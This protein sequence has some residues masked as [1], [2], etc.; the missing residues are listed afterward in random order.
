METGQLGVLLRPKSFGDMIGQEDVVKT[1]Q[2]QLGK[3]E[4][5]RA[6]M[7]I[8]PAGT[9]KTTLG[10]IIAREIQGWEFPA[11]SEPDVIEINAANKRKIED[12]RSLVDDTQ[13]FPFQGKYRVII[14]DEAQQITKEG[15]N[16]L[17]KPFEEKDSANVWIICTTDPQKIIEPLRTRC[18]IH[19]LTRLSKK[20]IH[21]LLTRGAEF[22]GRTEPYEDFEAEAIQRGGSLGPRA[23]LNAFQNYNNGTPAR[24]AVMTQTAE[25]GPEFFSIAKAVV[26]GSWDKDV[27]VWG[28]P[29]K[30]AKTLIGE[31][32]SALKKKA[33]KEKQAESE[34]REDGE[35]DQ[36]D[37]ASKPEVARTLRNI[38][39]ALLKSAVI[40]KDSARAQKAAEALYIMANSI[41][42]NEFDVPLEY[43]YTIGMLFRVNQKMN[44]K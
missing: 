28:N 35:P 22:L 8:G 27:P 40:G 13:S 12:I 14:L 34:F 24:E 18:S 36:E 37:L 1:L 25:A 23:I 3:G 43:P 42:A 2:T 30:A 16:V 4:V 11:D 21:D 19:Q 15:Q 6:Y 10:K 39:G 33:D 31:L 7:F 38:V 5:S 29:S 32:E 41:S 44:A 20:N 9:G 17:L 26:Y